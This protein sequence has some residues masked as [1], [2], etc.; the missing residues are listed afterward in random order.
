M[1][2]ATAA[3][4]VSAGSEPTDLVMGATYQATYHL[5]GLAHLHRMIVDLRGDATLAAG[6]VLVTATFPPGIRP[7]GH[8]YQVSG[9]L[10]TWGCSFTNTSLS[11]HNTSPFKPNS[12]GAYFRIGLIATGPV[13]GDIVS[14]VDPLNTVGE[15][16]E[17]NNSGV[18]HVS[19]VP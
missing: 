15:S 3:T 4:P 8:N 2:T 10:T 16:S 9:S 1:L 14:R 18:G 12:G 13:S 6:T 19:F 17:A 11:C 5:D 7:D